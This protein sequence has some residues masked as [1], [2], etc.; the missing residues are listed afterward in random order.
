MQR[1][2]KI[3]RKEI[4]LPLLANDKIYVKTKVSTLVLLAL[5]IVLERLWDPKLKYE[6]SYLYK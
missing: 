4:E 1:G 6:T 5:I 3:F 2:K